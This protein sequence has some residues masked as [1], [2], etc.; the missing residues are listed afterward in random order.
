MQ[1][2]EGVVIET[3]GDIA[4][5]RASKHSDCKNCGACPGNNSVI[6]SAKNLIGAVPGQRV[7][8]ET[9]ENNEVKGAFIVFILPLISTFA[10]VML[11]YFI[12]T[13]L[14]GYIFTFEILFGIIAFILSICYIKFFDH[15][16]KGS[17]NSYPVIIRIL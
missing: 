2:E 10:G 15:S 11:G 17:E 13:L 7:I 12:G 1:T 8:F 14:S 5:I 16:I 9:K 3:L 4:K 6:V